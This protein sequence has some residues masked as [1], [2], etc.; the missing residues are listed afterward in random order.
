[1]VEVADSEDEFKVFNRELS[2]EASNLDLG[3][4]FS[5]LINEMGIQ[6]KPK[7]S[8]LDLIESQPGRDAPRKAAQAKL[9]TPSQTRVPTPPPTLPSQ[10]TE[11]KRKKDAKGKRVIG[12]EQ[13]L[14][15]REDEVQRAPKQARVGQRGAEKRSDPQM[16]PPA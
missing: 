11:L 4:P 14:P 3:P 10:A 9:P 8:L 6:H 13:I 15:P 7:S 12:A 16:R 5:P 1:M 2:P